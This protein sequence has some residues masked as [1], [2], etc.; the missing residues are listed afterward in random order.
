PQVV[1]QA[2]NAGYLVGTYD[3]YNTGIAKGVNDSWLTAQ[4]PD[5][6]RIDCAIQGADGKNV[7]GFQGNGFYL[8]PACRRDYVEQRV[9]DI[10]HYGRFNSLFLDVDATA[11]ARE[12][13]SHKQGMSELQMLSAFNQRM[14]WISQQGVVLGSED[15]NALTTQGVAFA[16]G[17]VTL[18]FGWRDP[19]M[20]R[21][22][23]SPYYLGAWYPD[24]RPAVFFK[25]AKV[26][27]PYKTLLFSPEFKVPLYQTVFHDEVINSH[28]W[29]FDS[30]KFSDVKITRDLLSMLYNTPAMVHLSREDSKTKTAPRIKA[31]KHYQD[32]FY[33]IHS[34]LW[35][36]ALTDF[37]WLDDK[38]RLQQTS[39]SDGSKIIANFSIKEDLKVEN[40]LIPKASVVAFLSNGKQVSWQAKSLSK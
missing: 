35:D 6:M 3:S 26:K 10:L 11:M 29:L 28:H 15:G 8:N 12:D 38:G 34:L 18:G 27:E 4:L 20:K 5:D 13:Y 40:Q 36:K 32:G 24:D 19:D 2:K 31:L 30:L 39:F 25:S 16:H 7:K 33:P 9:K 22:R 14:D 37:R 17:M 23:Q 1:D 21:D